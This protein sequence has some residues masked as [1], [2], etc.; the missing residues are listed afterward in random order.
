MRVLPLLAKADMGMVVV[1]EVGMLLQLL[2]V[3]GMG[4]AEVGLL[5]PPAMAGVA[6]FIS[7]LVL[8]PPPKT[9]PQAFVQNREGL[10]HLHVSCDTC[11]F[12]T[13]Q[14]QRVEAREGGIPSPYM[15]VGSSGDSG[16]VKGMDW[17]REK[18]RM[19]VGHT[20]THHTH[21]AYA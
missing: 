20:L 11:N 6:Q 12:N 18:N 2:A 14:M 1:A 15:Y 16:R 19:T 5:L 10:V 21:S 9:P 8:M 3:A 13:R 7:S 17:D 4:V